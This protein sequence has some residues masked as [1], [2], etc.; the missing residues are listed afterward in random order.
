M[1]EIT[2]VLVDDHAMVRKGLRAFLDTETDLAIVGEAADGREAIAVVDTLSQTR[3]PDVVL[4][5]LLMPGLDGIS[6][7][8]HLRELYPDLKIVALTS[9]TDAA[10]VNGAMS[11]GVNGYLLKNASPEQVAEAVR[12]AARGQAHI[13]PQVAMTVANSAR[14]AALPILSERETEVVTLLAR[15]FSN[16]QIADTLFLSER[17]ARTHVSHIISKLGLD[18]RIQVALWAIREGIVTVS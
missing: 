2:I 4:M 17:T 3:A 16:Q 14:G 10:T 18:S 5:D 12:T 6:T 1:T 8:H 9:S 15:G 7:I 11:A 13:D